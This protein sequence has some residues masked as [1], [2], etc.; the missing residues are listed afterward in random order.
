M[1]VN[2]HVNGRERA[3]KST[4]RKSDE[5]RGKQHGERR[6]EKGERV[7]SAKLG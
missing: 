3:Q 5:E 1:A 4:K 6:T 7:E 2:V